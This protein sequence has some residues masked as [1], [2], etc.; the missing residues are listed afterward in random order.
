M[1]LL[2]VSLLPLQPGRGSAAGISFTG[3]MERVGD[4]SISVKLADHRVIDAMLPNTAALGSTAIAARFIM[5]DEVEI[6]CKPIQP[7]WEEATSRF[8]S[9]QVSAIRFLRR[10]SPE[11]VSGMLEAKAREGK[12]LLERPNVIAVA[13]KRVANP[14]AA[15][16]KEL[17]HARRVN[18]EYAANM[19]NFVADETAK[20]YRSTAQSPDWRA[21]TAWNRRSRSADAAR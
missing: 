20:R 8:Q 14:D 13:P 9:L 11:E 15:G 16:S 4:Q 1:L 6:E 3:S 19:P 5:G 21:S 17:E 18:L 7:V 10:P 2:L 12:N